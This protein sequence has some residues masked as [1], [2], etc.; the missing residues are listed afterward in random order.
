[1]EKIEEYTIKVDDLVV[2]VA[3]LGGKGEMKI[4]SIAVPTVAP[5][6]RAL[7]NYIKHG[8]ISEVSISTGE[9]LDPKSIVQLKEKFGKRAVTLLKDKLPNI[10]AETSTLLI[11]ILIQEMLGLGDVEYLLND[12][13]L[14]EIVIN[15]SS[16][17]VR[18][19]HKRYGWLETNIK[20]ESE[21]KILNYS[22]IIARRVG[23]QITTLN[24]LL[25]AHL[26][27]GD[28]ANA[29][30][31]PIC[32]KGHTITI[33]KFARD[34]WTLTDFIKN[35]TVTSH[36][37]A[38]IWLAI[39]YEMNV[40]VSGGTGSGKTSFLNIVMPFMPPNHRIVS[41]EDSVHGDSSLYYVENSIL[42][43]STIGSLI[44]SKLKE[45]KQI[46][47]DGTE[48]FQNKDIQ[49]LSV[50]KDG[51]VELRKPSS[52]IRHFVEKDMY[53]FNLASGKNIKVTSDHSLFSLV[54]NKL[55]A[56][57][58]A[59]LSI[60][61]VLATP[62]IL[63]V[64]GAAVHFDL[65]NYLDYF[66]TFQIRGKGL[67][68]LLLPMKEKLLRYRSKAQVLTYLRLERIPV[69]VLLKIGLEIPEALK[70]SLRLLPLRSSRHGRVSIPLLI[71]VDKDLSC[72]AG[73][74]LADGSYDKNS[75]IFSV[76]EDACNAYVQRISNRIC[77]STPKLHSDGLS[78][79][80]HSTTFKHFFKHVLGLEG[81]AYTKRVPPWVF[82]LPKDELTFFLRGYMSGDGLPRENDVVVGSCSLGLL[83]DVQTLFLRL[84]IL[85]RLS[86]HQLKDKTYQSFI[87]GSPFLQRFYDLGGFLQERQNKKLHHTISEQPK[88]S[89][90]VIP[91]TKPSY[92]LLKHAFGDNFKDSKNY[93]SWKSWQGMYQK[94]HIGRSVLQ[95][96]FNKFMPLHTSLV[97][98]PLVEEVSSL[99]FNDLFWDR[100]ISINKQQFKGNVYDFSVP[101]TENFIC[102]NIVCHNTR[103]LQLPKYLYWCP[104]T[105][106]QPNPE[107]KGEVTMLDLLINSL[108]MRPDRIIL[109]EMRKKDQASVLFEAMHTGHSV[110]AT[111]HADSIAE[112]ID[113][114]INPPIEVPRNLLTGVHLNVVMFRDRRRGIR[115]VFQVG[116]FLPTMEDGTATVKPN[117]LYRWKPGTDEIVEHSA[118]V[119]IF[120][121]LS[122]HTGLTLPQIEKDMLQKQKILDWMVA[123]NIR[124]VDAVGELIRSYYI[125]PESVLS[126]VGGV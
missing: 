35:K 43:Q 92:L 11:N 103:E 126:K 41:I 114:L 65:T 78:L 111:V 46:L 37:L 80:I 81:N 16:E 74:W 62:R 118:S 48:V 4:Y 51:K 26:I 56:V 86:R 17:P 36:V 39:Q 93:T 100:I 28:R 38:L 67:Q 47:A 79:M 54:N 44:D 113:R 66:K 102:E 33:R 34:P 75:V 73:L 77:H 109:G 120:E 20:M 18:V 68:Q 22:N 76:V 50:T 95:R 32:T 24:P 59:D 85:F 87:S 107:G 94:S 12:E 115:R 125:D 13:A 25:D 14:E 101:G 2:T 69:S 97:N 82:S 10:T 45:Q 117:I 91:L 23:R 9:M 112:T 70:L 116:E 90:D 61:D 29:V 5:A 7:M 3:I 27:T 96:L 105:I 72:L 6:T 121:E 98:A 8:L 122:R 30:L 71:S 31:F 110:Y 53:E 104:L 108:R 15:S 55:Q 83:E 1:M 60:G 84:G 58:C 89:S 99:A 19:F 63:P 49:I 119:R 64:Q 21:E 52:F 57:R 123:N 106:R 40:L 42:R 88:E 124:H